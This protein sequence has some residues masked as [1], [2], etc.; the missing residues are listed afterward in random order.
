MFG[1]PQAWWWRSVNKFMHA[2]ASHCWLVSHRIQP[3]TVFVLGMT[4]V[5]VSGAATSAR[6]ERAS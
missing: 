6:A 3:S 5:S 4:Q 2:D 1:V